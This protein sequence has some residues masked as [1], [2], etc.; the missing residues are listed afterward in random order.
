MY[1]WQWP[2]ANLLLALNSR[3]DIPN[4]MFCLSHSWKDA[5]ANHFLQPVYTGK[6]DLNLQTNPNV[7]TNRL[8]L[9]ATM[10]EVVSGGSSYL[11]RRCTTPSCIAKHYSQ[12]TSHDVSLLATSYY[13]ERTLLTALKSVTESTHCYTTSIIPLSPSLAGGSCA[14]WMFNLIVWSLMYKQTW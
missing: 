5:N 6:Y 14:Y 8:H 4:D 3:Q 7:V 1:W 9:I 12:P 13:S 2:S 10:Y 11:H